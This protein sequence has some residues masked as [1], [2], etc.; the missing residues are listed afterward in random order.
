MAASSSRQHTCEATWIKQVA[1]RVTSMS[2]AR[3][4]RPRSEMRSASARPSVSGRRFGEH[5]GADGVP[6]HVVVGAL[7]CTPL[8]LSRPCRIDVVVGFAIEA[9]E[10]VSHHI[11]ARADRLM[12]RPGSLRWCITRKRTKAKVALARQPAVYCAGMRSLFAVVGAWLVGCA[13]SSR[14]C[15]AETR[16]ASNDQPTGRVEWCAKNTGGVAAMPAPGRSFPSLLGMAHP[17]AMSGGLH[18]PFTHWY[19]SGAVESHGSYVDDGSTSVADGVWGFWYPDGSRKSMGRYVHGRPMGCFVVWDERG[20]QVTGIVEG[21]QIRVERC[22]PPSDETLTQIETRSNPQ[23][24]RSLW[25][26]VAIHAFP[27]TGVFGASN[28]TQ[29]DPDPSARLTVQGALRKHVGRFRVGAALG[30]RIADSDDVRAYSAGAVG[31]YSVPLPYQRVGIE[32]EAQFGVQ[33]LDVTARRADVL[34]TS[35]VSFWSPLF[36]ARLATSFALMPTV[37]VVGGV[38]LDGTFASTTDQAVSYCAPFCGPPIMETWSIGGVAYGAD[39]GLRLMI[40]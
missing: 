40:R 26:D 32:V 38:S 2:P 22:E 8:D 9:G 20:A 36:G 27:Q 33:Y 4:S 34:G 35:S 16:L 37:A 23:A 19:P 11:P 30:V 31:A 15:P 13:T 17:A 5:L 12:V 21:D 1:S 28:A 29:R 7:T 10:Q 3:G 39:L 18:G 24:R 14:V 25:G 6:P